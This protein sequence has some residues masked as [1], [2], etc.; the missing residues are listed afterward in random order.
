M[1]PEEGWDVPTNDEL[2]VTHWDSRWTVDGILCKTSPVQLPFDPMPTNVVRVVA[3]IYD[4]TATWTQG[5]S[6]V[7]NI[8][9]IERG[10]VNHGDPAQDMFA[11][12]RDVDAREHDLAAART[13]LA[14]HIRG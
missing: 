13:L 5:L 10:H 12:N 6:I 14:K 7:P 8:A 1:Q 11:C 4:K 2:R 3:Q 9:H